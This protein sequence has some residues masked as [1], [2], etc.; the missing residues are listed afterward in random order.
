MYATYIDAISAGGKQ[1]IK[2][3]KLEFDWAISIEEALKQ[4]LMVVKVPQFNSI[5]NLLVWC[6]ENICTMDYYYHDPL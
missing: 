3:L 2:K 6:M 1:V 4:T 5:I